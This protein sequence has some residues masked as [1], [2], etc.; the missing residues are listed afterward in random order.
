VVV[1]I[2]LIKPCQQRM[3]GHLFPIDRRKDEI[4]EVAPDVATRAIKN[5]LAVRYEPQV[6]IRIPD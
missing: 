4:V 5:G 6:L 2:R 3:P 1:W